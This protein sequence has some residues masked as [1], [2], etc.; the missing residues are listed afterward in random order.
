M[1]GLWKL[2]TTLRRGA[3]TMDLPKHLRFMPQNLVEVPYTKSAGHWS[4]QRPAAGDEAAATALKRSLF[5]VDVQSG[6][7]T[8][9]LRLYFDGLVDDHRMAGK[10]RVQQSPAALLSDETYELAEEEAD[11]GAGDFL[12]T[13]VIMSGNTRWRPTVKPRNRLSRHVDLDLE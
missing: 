6:E 9:D 7:G 3:L 4:L 8:V 5:R 10:F 12:C 11:S 2:S 1:E 13:R